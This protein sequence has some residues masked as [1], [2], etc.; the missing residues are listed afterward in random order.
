[1]IFK[2]FLIFLVVPLVELAI[3]IKVGQVIGLLN[4]VLLV[5][6]TALLGAFFARTQGVVILY[7]IK[8][9]LSRGRPPGDA[10]LEGLLIL[11]AGLVLLTPGLLTD[12]SGFLL[13]APPTRKLAREWIKRIIKRKI[14]RRGIYQQDSFENF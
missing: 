7:R 13:L 10:L 12:I 2:L 6:L 11:V 4:T 8:F 5:V 9:E 1:M 14:D 3:L